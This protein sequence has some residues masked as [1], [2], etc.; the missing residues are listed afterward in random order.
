MKKGLISAIFLFQVVLAIANNG[1]TYQLYKNGQKYADPKI[2]KII[3]ATMLEP[4]RAVNQDRTYKIVGTDIVITLFSAN[5]LQTKYNRV[6][7]PLN[8]TDNNKYSGLNFGISDN[9]FLKPIF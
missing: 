1:M 8:I 4:F 7:S 3:K 6:I 2:E 9:R 5:Y